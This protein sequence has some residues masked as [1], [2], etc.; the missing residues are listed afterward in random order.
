MKPDQSFEP[1][2]YFISKA[3]II[4]PISVVVAALIFKFVPGNKIASSTV[5][6]VVPT[7]TSA[8]TP[9]PEKFKFDLKGPSVCETEQSGASLSAKIKDMQVSALVTQGKSK[10]YYVLTKDCF[11]QWDG[12]TKQGIKFCGIGTMISLASMFGNMN[13]SLISSVLPSVMSQM[14][15]SSTSSSSAALSIDQIK[16]L[17]QSCTKA[18]VPDST[19]A[20]PKNVSF[21][22]GKLQQK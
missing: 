18:E 12:T 19:F 14:A 8:P 3:V 15:P 2:I 22:E 13:E 4:I 10:S 17:F 5:T 6:K 1:F 11:H 16:M 9:S 7:A 21:T 20:I